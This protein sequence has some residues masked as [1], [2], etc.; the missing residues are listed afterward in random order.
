MQI[1]DI[2]V[3]IFNAPRAIGIL[4]G[5]HARKP[6][7]FGVAIEL[8]HH[9]CACVQRALDG[10]VAMLLQTPFEHA[11][12]LCIRHAGAC[13]LLRQQCYKIAAGG[14]GLK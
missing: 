14:M 13:L 10:L 8:G 7:Q 3:V 9:A 5:C 2:S 1:F 4:Q 11:L 12:G 6:R